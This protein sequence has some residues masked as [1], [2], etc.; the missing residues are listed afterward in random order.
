MASVTRRLFNPPGDLVALT[1]EEPLLFELADRLWI[2]ARA[3]D[4]GDAIDV[5]EIEVVRRAPRSG[6]Q[7][8]E[9][10]DSLEGAGEGGAAAPR[11]PRRKVAPFT[12][13]ESLR[14]V[15]EPAEFRCEVPGVL[16][17]TIDLIG[18]KIRAALA[19]A[20]PLPLSKK[21]PSFPLRS[22][23]NLPLSKNSPSSLRSSLRSFLARTLLEAPAAV[24]LARRGW[25]ALHAGAVRGTKGAVVV[26]GDAGAGKS[27]LVAA[28]HLAGLEVLGDE[29]LL[30]SRADPDELASSVRELTLCEDSAALL[31]LISRTEAAFSGGEAKRRVDLFAFSRPEARAAHRVATL[32]LGPRAPGPARLVPL[33]PADF[34]EEF[35]RGAIPQEAVDGGAE[36]IAR[37]W[38]E[39][40]GLRL[41][42]A[43][44]LQG[45]VALLKNLVT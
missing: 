29:S 44:D 23:P 14:W 13:E 16:G 42:G 10:E 38:A 6:G 4:T 20:L 30:V 25:R 36:T 35:A 5:I 12:F 40:G 17:V 2:P 15:H 45:A 26:R 1:S 8:G 7:D 34:L 27:T 3:R 18:A 21:S 43:S 28:A 37:A 11:S 31:D 39:A 9:Y 33:A 22:F 19:P 41:D 32:L 24:L